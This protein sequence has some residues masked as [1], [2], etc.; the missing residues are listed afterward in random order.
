MKTYPILKT[1]TL[2]VIVLISCGAGCGSEKEAP[3]PDGYNTLLGQWRLYQVTTYQ[4]KTD[5]TNH[6][7]SYLAADR[8]IKITWDF[9]SNGDFSA[10]NEKGETQTGKW[11]LKVTRSAGNFIDEGTL[12]LTG[13]W[14]SE[15][16]KVFGKETLDYGISQGERDGKPTFIAGIET[17]YNEE[18]NLKMQILYEYVK[19]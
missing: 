19:I 14:A 10:T 2:A 17:I 16:A 4:Q 3:K 13:S 5:G 1:L 11:S 12:T 8:G 7:G 15:T 9:K 6:K 18:L